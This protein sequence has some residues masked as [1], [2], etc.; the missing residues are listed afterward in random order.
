MSGSDG[1]VIVDGRSGKWCFLLVVA[2][3]SG[4]CGDSSPGLGWV[5]F[6]GASC[7]VVL[8]VVLEVLGVVVVVAV[9]LD[10]VVLDVVV[11]GKLGPDPPLNSVISPQVINPISARTRTTQAASSGGL[12]YQGVWAAKSSSP[13][14]PG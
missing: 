7:A 10:V 8:G 1:T 5:V 4:D 14:S 9:V 13:G 12:R 2:G 6:G 11:D 3:A